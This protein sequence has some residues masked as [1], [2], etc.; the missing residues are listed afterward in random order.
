M[1]TILKNVYKFKKT[2]AY[3]QNLYLHNFNPILHVLFDKRILN[4][5][6]GGKN[7]PNLTPKPIVIETPNLI[8]GL[9]IT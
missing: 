9:V 1:F 5:W 3:L 8:C 4:G 6:E 7:A 2:L